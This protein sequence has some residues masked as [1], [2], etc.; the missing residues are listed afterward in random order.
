MKI[1][2]PLSRNINYKYYYDKC[3]DIINPIKLGITPKGKGK[4]QI[5][6]KAGMYNR[7]FDD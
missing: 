4:T 6:K 1:F 5:R 2:Y 7:L 3:Y